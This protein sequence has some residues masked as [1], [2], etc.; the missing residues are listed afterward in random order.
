MKQFV[1]NNS[2]YSKY[3]DTWL[4]EFIRRIVWKR[5]LERACVIQDSLVSN[6]CCGCLASVKGLLALYWVIFALML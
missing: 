4:I 5:E 1:F 3:K 6:F 2:K